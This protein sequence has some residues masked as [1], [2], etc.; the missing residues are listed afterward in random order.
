V[1]SG[2]GPEWLYERNPV[3]PRRVSAYLVDHAARAIVFHT[4]S[5]LR[6]EL[7]IAGWAQVLTL[8]FDHTQLAG[9]ISSAEVPTIDGV[10]FTRFTVARDGK[11][12]EVWW[13]AAQLLPAEFSSIDA[14]GRT[15]LSIQRIRAVDETVLQRPQSRFP[16]Y[17]GVDLAEWL[18]ER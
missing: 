1:A 12:L 2:D 8:G 11:P 7:A 18:E 15:R 14:T 17:R 16:Q 4:D 9:A 3:D 5:D 10:A 13:N 6:N